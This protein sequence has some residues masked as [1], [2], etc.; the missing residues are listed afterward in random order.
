MVNDIQNKQ[1]NAV[2]KVIEN[3]MKIPH[4]AL[5]ANC[6]INP[7]DEIRYDYGD[8]TVHWRKVS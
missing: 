7:G 8:S 1:A 6:E 3:E 5:F 4:L 2:M